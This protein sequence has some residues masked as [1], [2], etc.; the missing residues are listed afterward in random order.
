[1]SQ[2]KATF[3]ERALGIVIERPLQLATAV[4]VCLGLAT[5]GYVLSDFSAVEHLVRPGIAHPSP[6]ATVLR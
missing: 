6:A 3:N 1:M 5:A 4:I 2:I